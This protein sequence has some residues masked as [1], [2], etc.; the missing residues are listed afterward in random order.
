MDDGKLSKLSDR[1]EQP[2]KIPSLKKL[3]I[4]H[5]GD[6]E[7]AYTRADHETVRDAI[8][9]INQKPPEA[10]R[11]LLVYSIVAFRQLR[12]RRNRNPPAMRVGN[13]SY[14]KMPHSGT[15]R[16][17]RSIV[18]ERSRCMANQTNSLA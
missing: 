4:F 3:W 7:G 13:K 18:Q 10:N 17:F 6:P 2:R 16:V 14:T 11:R 15:I 8:P 1:G 12:R 5:I 9:L